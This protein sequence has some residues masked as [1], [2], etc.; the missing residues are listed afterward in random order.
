MKV[1]ITGAATTKFGELWAISPRSLAGE[2][3]GNALKDAHVSLKRI[4]A[5]FVCNMLSGML[6]G[7]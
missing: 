1:Y 3:V 5:L 2:A 7:Q 4:Q 6:C